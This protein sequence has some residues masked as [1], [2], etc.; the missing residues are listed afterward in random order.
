VIARGA[1][2][3]RVI[4]RAIDPH[5]TQFL[6]NSISQRS[7]ETAPSRGIRHSSMSI[8]HSAMCDHA[9][10]ESIRVDQLG[11]RLSQ[12]VGGGAGR[13]VDA[14]ACTK[15]TGT[16]LDVRHSIVPARSLHWF[17][18]LVDGVGS[19]LPSVL[20]TFLDGTSEMNAD[21]NP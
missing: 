1:G 5:L 18:Q 2:L 16:G 6:H 11:R 7:H 19:D 15:V 8:T 20:H 12:D 14:S 9:S 10:P 4:V 21:V 13:P 3:L 17:Q